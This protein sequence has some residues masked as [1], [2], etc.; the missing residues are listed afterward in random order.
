MMKI[1]E[2]FTSN[3]VSN[4]FLILKLITVIAFI[5]HWTACWFYYVS[6]EESFNSYDAMILSTGTIDKTVSEQYMTSLYW[7]LTTMTTVGYGDISP[8][9]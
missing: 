4:L 7:A 5:A 9:T 2:L 6:F 3:A 8:K 1:D